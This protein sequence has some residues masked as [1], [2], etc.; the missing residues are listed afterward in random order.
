MLHL[1]DNLK[2]Q[3]NSPM[4]LE[5]LTTPDRIQY[6][7]ESC[8]MRGVPHLE[9]ARWLFLD[10]AMEAETLSVKQLMTTTLVDMSMLLMLLSIDR[11]PRDFV[12]RL[13]LSFAERTV[14]HLA[15][16]LLSI[17]TNGDADFRLA[18]YFTQQTYQGLR[19]WF[20]RMGQYDH[21]D[22][23]VV[24]S[25]KTL[26]AGWKKLQGDLEGPPVHDF[27]PSTLREL[28]WWPI[29]VNPFG[30]SGRKFSEVSD[31]FPFRDCISYPL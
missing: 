10:A 9:S 15:L 2:T 14:I 24:M 16:R 3:I 8:S 29:L 1:C 17:R 31:R 23:E 22:F 21:L 5:F 13:R 25:K 4:P 18:Y 11:G 6:A 7:R 28:G 30:L 19:C 20:F 27:E 12:G 26:K